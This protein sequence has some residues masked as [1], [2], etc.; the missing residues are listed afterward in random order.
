MI[1]NRTYVGLDVHERSVWACDVDDEY[2][3]MRTAR[4][5]TKNAEIVKWAKAL[6]GA[7]E[8][9]YENGTK[10]FDMARALIDDEVK[11]TCWRRRR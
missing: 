2:G 9:A 10:G 1:K 5:S 6:T 8:V 3:E 4:I 7:V 11:C